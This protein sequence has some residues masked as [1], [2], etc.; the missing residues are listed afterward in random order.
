MNAMTKKKVFNHYS[1]ILN[2]LIDHSVYFDTY[3]QFPTYLEDSVY[4]DGSNGVPEY[5]SMAT[6]ATRACL[7]DASN[8]YVVKFDIYSDDVDDSVCER[9]CKLFEHAKKHRLEQYF[10]EICYVGTFKKTFFFYE[11]EDVVTYADLDESI[12]T[13]E[14]HFN[15]NAYKFD[16]PREITITIDLYACKKADFFG[17]PKNYH[18]TYAEQETLNK[19][20]SPLSS[21]SV[22]VGNN[23]FKIYGESEY[24]RLSTFLQDCDINDLHCNNVGVCEGAFILLDYAGYHDF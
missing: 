21:R 3:L 10:N 2:D 24:Y 1:D 8:P 4:G 20:D 12:E 13:F 5:I 7:I 17:A 23:F 9:E 18:L 16:D 22:N 6:G 15:D 19:Y 11:Y 14:R